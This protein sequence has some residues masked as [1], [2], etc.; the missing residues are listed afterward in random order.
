MAFMIYGLV[1]FARAIGVMAFVLCG[2]VGLVDLV[3]FACAIGV[4][5]FMICG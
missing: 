4:I 2:L 3:G 5:A 1:D